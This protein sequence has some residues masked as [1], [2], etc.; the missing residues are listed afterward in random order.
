ML[1]GS[2]THHKKAVRGNHYPARFSP[3][4]LRLHSR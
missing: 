4:R 2:A 3:L 1:V